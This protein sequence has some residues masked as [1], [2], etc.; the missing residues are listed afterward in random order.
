MITLKNV[1]MKGTLQSFF[2][3]L[4]DMDC[5]FVIEWLEDYFRRRHNVFLTGAEFVIS[6]DFDCELIS[7]AVKR[8]QSGGDM[9][10][11]KDTFM[12]FGDARGYI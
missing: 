1:G 4:L 6:K 12:D 7:E 5:M 2:R 10:N 3:E 11:L 8:Y 9:K